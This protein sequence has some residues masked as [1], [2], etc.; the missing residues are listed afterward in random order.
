MLRG[1]IVPDLPVVLYCPSEALWP[2]PEFAALLPLVSKL[3]I[4]SESME[5]SPSALA[6]LHAL[7]QTPDCEKL[8][9]CGRGSLHGVSRYAQ[10]FEDPARMR[11]VYDLEEIQ[12]LYH[13][14]AWRAVVRLLS[15]RMVHERTWAPA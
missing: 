8:I 10:I 1:L 2:L 3:I 13:W 6:Y 4:D 15:G 9:W 12:I 5:N 14:P 7:P 11:S